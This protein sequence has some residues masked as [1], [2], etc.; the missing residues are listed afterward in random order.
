ML[1]TKTNSKRIIVN[2]HELIKKSKKFEIANFNPNQIANYS[3]GTCYI[4]KITSKRLIIYLR[5]KGCEWSQTDFG[6]C[7]M[8]GHFHGTSKGLAFEKGIFVEQIRA[9]LKEVEILDFPVVCIYNAGSL[10]NHDE[11]PEE[12]LLTIF[13]IIGSFPHIRKIIIETRPEY[14]DLE[15]ITLLKKALNNCILEIGI[16]L[17]SADDNIRDLVINKGFDFKEYLKAIKI[18]KQCNVKILTYLTVKHLFQTNIESIEDTMNSIK[19]L[20]GLTDAISLEPLSIQKGT[21]VD[22]FYKIGKYQPPK[23][24][25]IIDIINKIKCLKSQIEIRIGGF[26]FYP[27]PYHVINN[28]SN[29]TTLLYEYINLYNS[30]IDTEKVLSLNCDCKIFYD[31]IIQHELNSKPELLE[32][33]IANT[34][35]EI[36]IGE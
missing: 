27:A 33:R 12:E 3:I 10:L 14:V 17:E 28:C 31:E 5:S 34:I 2:I 22:L 29:C 24:W 36:L 6:G 23:G 32:Q 1:N 4:N 21:L 20:E 7:F 18:L 9:I 11:V 35:A 25:L 16:G 13:Q 15:Y 8:C 30:G 19:L 26:E